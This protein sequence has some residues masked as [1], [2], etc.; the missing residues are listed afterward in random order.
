MTTK[1][2]SALI[3]AGV[4][5]DQEI[6]ERQDKFAVL[7]DQIRACAEAELIEAGTAKRPEELKGQNW[8]A[9][10]S[11]GNWVDVSWPEDKLISS[12]FFRADGAAFRAKDREVIPLDDIRKLSG[13]HF[14][15]LFAKQFRP[16]KAFRELAAVLLGDK[17]GGALIAA[18][19]EPNSPRVAFK[20]KS[21]GS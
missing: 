11:E 5:L 16:A 9:Q 12:F 14:E 15:K 8:S 20:L 17:A 21:P 4:K 19:S 18:V 10:G 1:Q 6:K 7:K 3:D 2:L 13:N